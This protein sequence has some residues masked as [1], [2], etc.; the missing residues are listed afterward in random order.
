M[1]AMWVATIPARTAMPSGWVEASSRQERASRLFRRSVDMSAT[2]SFRGSVCGECEQAGKRV[3]QRGLRLVGEV[4]GAEGDV[5]IG[6]DEQAAAIADL[7]EPAP[8]P[9]YVVVFA[10]VPDGVDGDV[11]AELGRHFFGG[12]A[13]WL[14]AD[15]DE[16]AEPAVTGQIQGGDHLRSLLHPGVRQP[17]AGM[18]GGVVE[19]FGVAG[20]LR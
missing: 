7:A 15:A 16:E 9:E 4:G 1:V 2:R 20:R 11:E 12:F 19:E 5:L 18:G 17:G 3:S 6:P 14:T 10:A 8:V 13:P